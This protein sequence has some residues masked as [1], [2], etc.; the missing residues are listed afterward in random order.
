M[1]SKSRYRYRR[2]MFLCWMFRCKPAYSDFAILLV[3]IRTWPMFLHFSPKV[4]L[5]INLVWAT[6]SK[7][8]RVSVCS[9]WVEPTDS[10]I[11]SDPWSLHISTV[12][13]KCED[14]DED[15]KKLTQQSC[16][17]LG[18]V[19]LFHAIF[20]DPAPARRRGGRTSGR[21]CGVGTHDLSGRAESWHEHVITM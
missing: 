3:R 16:L 7:G 13:A 10:E 11:A 20:P 12:T 5:S 19:T 21:R 8:L 17:Y 2:S 4:F 18:H 9:T 1:N 15:Q 6:C 14:M